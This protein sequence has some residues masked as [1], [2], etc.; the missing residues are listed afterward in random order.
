MPMR[1]IPYG[2][3]QISQEDIE[4]IES[5]LRSDFL[6]QGP[7][8]RVFEEKIGTYVGANHVVTANSATSAL[9]L[10]CKA[11]D[12]GR[13]DT[14]WTTPITFVASANCALYCNANVGFVDIDPLTGLMSTQDLED[15]LTSAQKDGTV[16]KALIVVHLAGNSCEMRTIFALAQRFGVKVIEDASHA[17]G[18]SYQGKRVG[19]CEF[20]E[21]CIFSF[22]PVKMI[23]TGEG[24]AATTNDPRLAQRM[25]SLRSHGITKDP[26]MFEEDD[27][28]SWHYEQQDLG[29]NYRMPD[30]NA[31]LGISQL[32][33]LDQ[34]IHRRREIDG[35]YRSAL[36]NSPLRMLEIT[37]CCTS[38][39]HLCIVSLEDA[40]R[41]I[42]RNKFEQMRQSGIGVQLHYRPVHLNPYFRRLGFKKGMYPNA[43]R[44]AE[45][46]FSLPVFPGLTDEELE[47]ILSILLHQAV[48]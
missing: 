17:L 45:T 16:P 40:N 43:E 29:F 41:E 42:H 1:N 30:I 33:R 6:T 24:G 35:R 39:V 14:V 46:C 11:L 20:S 7:M 31:A 10:A 26:D 48:N 28:A 44:Y 18:S 9:H 3:Q 15:K 34:N 23:T 21:I 22:H 38:S 5:V 25:R 32:R 12:I 8:G 36:K 4:A 19:C 2:R 13:G 27:P 37:D 47:Y